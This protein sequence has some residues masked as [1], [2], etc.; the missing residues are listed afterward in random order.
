MR[1]GWLNV[2][3][4][5]LH[6][7]LFILIRYFNCSVY[8]EIILSKRKEKKKIIMVSRFMDL[9]RKTVLVQ[10]IGVEPLTFY[11]TSDGT[12]LIQDILRSQLSRSDADLF[13]QEG[14][15]A[16]DEQG[17]FLT[18]EPTDTKNRTLHLPV[19]H[20]AY[21]GALRRMRRDLSDQRNP[22]QI[23]RREF[24]NVDLANRFAHYIIGPP[25]FAAVF[26]G[27]DSALC[28][29]FVTQSSDDACLLV[30]KLMRAFKLYEQQ[31]GQTN[32]GGSPSFPPIHSGNRAPSPIGDRHR[33][34]LAQSSQTF[35]NDNRQILSSPILHQ[36][37][38]A[39]IQDPRNDELIQR[40]LANPNLQLVSQPTPFASQRIDDIPIISGPASMVSYS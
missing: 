37:Q 16:V 6:L 12:D 2:S 30:M 14:S 1:N 28:Y 23:Q 31:Q 39:Y 24:E 32:Q 10:F 38:N 35:F 7:V 5:I 26:H 18:F 22:D 40:L 25:I 27:F 11:S 29:T 21:C 4:K 3:I 36:A 33:S 20:L 34:P 13:G 19:E 15:L 17:E 9:E 8:F